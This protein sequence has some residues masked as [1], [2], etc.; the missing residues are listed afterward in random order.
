[1]FMMAMGWVSIAAAVVLLA[2]FLRGFRRGRRLRGLASLSNLFSALALLEVGL[3]LAGMM[4][5]AVHAN[6]SWGAAFA[7]VAACAQA[8]EVFRSRSGERWPEG[9][10]NAAARDRRRQG[11]GLGVDQTPT[12]RGLRGGRGS[13]LR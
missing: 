10:T 13:V 6:I 1:M 7:L 12:R 2:L 11:G 4:K 3:G 8:S 5:P 9:P